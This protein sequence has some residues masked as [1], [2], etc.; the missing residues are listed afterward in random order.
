MRNMIFATILSGCAAA[1]V[2]AQQC[3]DTSRGYIALADAGYQRESIGT[4]GADTIE[5]WVKPDGGFVIFYRTLYSLILGQRYLGVAAQS[6][7]QSIK[8]AVGESNPAFR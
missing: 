5:T 7:Q 8:P 4:T 2:T 6:A 1:P 3:I